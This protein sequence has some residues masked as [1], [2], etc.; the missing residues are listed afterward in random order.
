MVSEGQ[1][2]F[3]WLSEIYK[4]DVTDVASQLVAGDAS[5][6]K[7]YRITVPDTGTRMLMVSPPTE[8]NERFVLLRQV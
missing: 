1:Q 2:Q 5:P 4:C 7:L 6:R 8:N 3:H